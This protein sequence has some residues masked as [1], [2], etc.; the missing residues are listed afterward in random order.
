[1]SSGEGT[2]YSMSTWYHLKL[3]YDFPIALNSCPL[4]VQS[5]DWP[6][7]KKVLRGQIE[8]QF[9]WKGSRYTV[10]LVTVGELAFDFPVTVNNHWLDRYWSK[11]IRWNLREEMSPQILGEGI[12][13]EFG[14]KIKFVICHF[15]AQN[16]PNSSNGRHGTRLWHTYT[17]TYIL[18][19]SNYCDFA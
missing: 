2:S 6:T 18:G 13:I 4:A 5:M 8:P 10:K 7:F 11:R 1:M 16:L 9:S 12:R 3:A 19:H 14:R 15:P 17:R